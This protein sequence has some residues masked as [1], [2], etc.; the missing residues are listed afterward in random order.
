MSAATACLNFSE[1]YFG[2]YLCWFKHVIRKSRF[3]E[4]QVEKLYSLIG[5]VLHL[6]RKT[7]HAK[8]QSVALRTNPQPNPKVNTPPIN[9]GVHACTLHQPSS[10]AILKT[11]FYFT[12]SPSHHFS[13][14]KEHRCSPQASVHVGHICA[15]MSK[16]LIA[17]HWCEM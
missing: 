16:L 10:E 3:D 11:V 6:L 5:A 13:G 2:N 14:K 15:G 9:V 17:Y 4:N 7:Q 1:G 12:A 8:T